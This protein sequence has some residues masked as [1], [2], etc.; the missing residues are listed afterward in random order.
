MM[1]RGCWIIGLFIGLILSVQSTQAQMGF[2]VQNL[3]VNGG[4]TF[5]VPIGTFGDVAG[6]GFGFVV[7]GEYVF[8]PQISILAGLGYVIYG[9]KDFGSYRYNYSELPLTAGAKYYLFPPGKNPMRIFLLGEL[10]FHRM[11]YASEYQYELFGVP[12][13]DRYSSAVV[14][15]GLTPGAGVEMLVGNFRIDITGFMALITGSYSN[16]GL[17]STIHFD[18]PRK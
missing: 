12:R 2:S 18:L 9:G 8:T 11:G 3:G 5:K 13:V 4:L 6:V 14:R 7:Q 15:L 10:G 17:R 1:K 16:I